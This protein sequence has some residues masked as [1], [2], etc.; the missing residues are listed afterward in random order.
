MRKNGIR[1]KMKRKFKSNTDSHH[2]YPVAEN[3]VSQNFSVD[4]PDKLWLSDITYIY[5]REGWLYLSVVM[6]LFNREIIGWAMDKR[7][8]R[9]LVIDACERAILKRRPDKG[10]IFHSDRGQPVCQRRV[11]ETAEGSQDYPEYEWERELL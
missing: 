2:K 1:S 10:L 3:L 4:E 9:Q 6:D 8:K 5:T 7:L 11:Q